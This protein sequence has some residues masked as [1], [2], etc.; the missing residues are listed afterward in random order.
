VAKP[1]DPVT[2]Y[3]RAVTA[4]RVRCGRYV[5]L[6]CQRHLRDKK[7]RKARGLRF[8]EKAATV[9]IEFFGLLKHSKGKCAGKPFVLSPWQ[10]FIVG[11]LFG[12]KRA[13]D[14]R[15]FR[16]AYNELPRKNGKSTLAAGISILLAF[17]D[18]ETGAEVY[19][20]A[21]KRNQAKIVFDEA[22]RMVEKTPGLQRKIEVLVANLHVRE[23]S[24]KLEP[25]GADADSTDGLNVHGVIIDELHAHKTSAL[26]DVLQSASGS[27]AQPLR[28]EITTAGFDRLSV[29]WKHHDYSVKVLEGI[30]EDDTWFAFIASADEG[31]DW[32][33]ELTWQK[34]NPNLGV[35]V[36]PDYI[37]AE[38][39]RAEKIPGEQNTF[40]RLHLNE[41]TEQASRAI[42][43]ALWDAAAGQVDLE[44]LE[45]E[46]CMAGLDMAS[47]ND[48]A[49]EVK[50][51]G[52][53]P[54]GFYDVVPRFWIPE[55]SI[56]VGQS[57]RPEEIRRQLAEWVERGFITA[58]PGN[59]TDYDFVE[60]AILEDG[61]RFRL[62]ELA[63]DRWGV[64]QLITHLQDEWGT[65]DTAQIKVVDVGQG[66]ASM[67][68]PTKEFL[69]LVANGKIRHGGNPVLRWMVSNLALKQ[70][71][72]GN[73]KPDRESSG[74]KIDGVVGLIMALGRAMVQPK[75][76]P[77]PYD[78]HGLIFI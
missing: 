3:A 14:T 19:C 22:K 9:A 44:H 65:G 53:D 17:F 72:A 70:D 24:S 28:F 73:L 54:E 51:F 49:A 12:W 45:G 64:T 30:V 29:C 41:W 40:R 33:D 25:L 38:C 42:D 37:E 57:R 10:Q 20:A 61:V 52:P 62:R 78:E 15:R 35:S 71:A 8:D 7:E 60:K 32:R 18:G 48:L 46:P 4:G 69:R 55:A 66:F 47:T 77:S 68:G 34:A 39:R 2:D 63:F 23:S 27:R 6:A 56:A 5:R 26:V 74:D 36:Y 59:V 11:S 31:D 16:V 58:T 50:L 1:A 43:M 75:Q 76:E 13:D 21:T 67:A